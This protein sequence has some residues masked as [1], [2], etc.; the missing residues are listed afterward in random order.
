MTAYSRRVLSLFLSTAEID[1]RKEVSPSHMNDA[2]YLREHAS[3]RADERFGVKL[4]DRVHKAL[5]KRIQSGDAVFIRRC[6]KWRT[7]YL[8][9]LRGQRCFAIYDS[10]HS[11]IVTF[12]P[13]RG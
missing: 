13:T 4:T 9:D 1:D 11:T 7:K 2:D 12:I 3:E 10:K 8:V 6:N 5:V